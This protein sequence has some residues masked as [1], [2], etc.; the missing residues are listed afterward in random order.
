MT[1]KKKFYCS[2]LDIEKEKNNNIE[3]THD[4]K[5]KDGALKRDLLSVLIGF[6]KLR[7]SLDNTDIIF[8]FMG[9]TFTLESVRGVYELIKDK[10]VDKSNFR[11][12]SYRY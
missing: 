10:S 3:Y 7:S 11:K 12:N 4:V 6:K 5:V 1:I 9:K 2:F 8:K